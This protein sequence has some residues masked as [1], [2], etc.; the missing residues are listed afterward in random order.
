MVKIIYGTQ[1]AEKVIE[2]V[3]RDIAELKGRGI[4]PSL[5][6]ILVGNDS[7]SKIY[8]EKKEKKAKEIGI[9]SNV[10]E[11]LESTQE[12]ELLELIDKL[13]EDPKVHGILVQFPL[14]KQINERN[15]RESI[16]V[17]KDV[18]GLHSE[19]VGKLQNGIEELAPCTPKGIIR[20]LEEYQIQIAGKNAV[21]VGRSSLVGKPIANMLLNRNATVTIAH[22]KTSDLGEVTKKADILVVA[23]GKP[24]LIKEEM[25]KEGVVIIDVGINREPEGL[26][27]DVDYASVSKKVRAITP[28]PGGVGPMTIAM[29]MRNT[30]NCAK[31][32]TN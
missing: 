10:I 3:K 8:V 20:L 7:A 26:V 1:I 12:S 29:L 22:S 18:D 23:V 31:L 2:E 6:A 19:N 15:V 30:L 28:V 24:K 32:Q 16:S 14:P 4:E 27:G 5:T 21:V 17:N 11:L 25:V 9:T 13:N